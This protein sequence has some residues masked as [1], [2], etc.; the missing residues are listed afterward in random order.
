MAPDLL[1]N[2][3]LT[4]TCPVLVAP[5]MHTEMWLHPATQENVAVLRRRGVTVLEPA[6]GRLTGKDSGPGRLPEP[7]AQV[8]GGE[9]VEAKVLEGALRFDRVGRGVPEHRRGL[10]AHELQHERVALPVWRVGEPPR[11][12]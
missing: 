11:G 5:A 12:G 8:H 3:L 1:G 2:V 4:A 6:V 9:R 7:V 10:P